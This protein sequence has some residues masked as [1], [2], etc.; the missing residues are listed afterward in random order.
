MIQTNEIILFQGDSITDAMRSRELTEPNNIKALGSGYANFVAS[1]LLRDRS[2]DNLKFYNRGNSGDRIVDLYARW[3]TDAISLKPDLIS[4]LIGVNDAWHEYMRQDG[5]DVE[6]YETIYRL[7]LDYTQ[8][9]LPDVKLVLCEPFIL[10]CGEVQESWLE[11]MARR[12]QVIR[13]LANEFDACLVTFQACLDKALEDAPPEYWSI[14]G[15]HLTAA[16]HRVLADCWL[17]AVLAS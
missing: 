17:E 13:K 4:I 14:D 6:R 15:V 9:Q 1:Q 7:L 10:L 12:R 2:A 3:K 11:D 5:V 8:Q 16:G